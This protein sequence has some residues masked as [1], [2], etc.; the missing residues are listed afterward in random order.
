MKKNL[1]LVILVGLMFGGIGMFVG[2][3]APAGKTAVPG[4]AD[5][6]G[7]SSTASSPADAR[8]LAVDSLFAQ[9]M[10]DAAGVTQKLAQWRGK[11]MVVNFW[12][13]W[14]GP[15]VEE[16][17]ELSALQATLAPRRIQIIGIGI[18]SPTNIREFAGKY[19]IAYPLYVAGMSG[20]DLSKQFGNPSGSL[21]YTV[22]IDSSG[23]VAKTYL[24]KLKMEELRTDLAAL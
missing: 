2:N 9:S 18:D 6:A 1:L 7:A 19:K 15:C 13:T 14:C 11:P 4:T 12:A 10:P 16:M 22:L 8:V 17:P 23:K 5:A 3:R 20:T 21:P 24:G